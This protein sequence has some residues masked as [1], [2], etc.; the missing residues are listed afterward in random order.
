VLCTV[1]RVQDHKGHETVL[2]ALALLPEAERKEFVYVI[3]G[4]G[5]H[6][7]A[8]REL[9]N[10]LGVSQLVSWLGFVADSELPLVYQAADVFVLCTRHCAN[11]PVVEG[12]GLAFLEAQA[13]AIPVIGTRTGGIVDAIDEKAG[14]W[15]IEQDDSDRLA[16]LL[17]ELVLNPQVFIEAGKLARARVE[18]E[19]TWDHYS[20][21]LMAAFERYCISVS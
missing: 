13:C 7:K 10:T 18:K 2:R 17:H 5:P 16:Q 4:K 11:P 1:A 9:T 21:E 19:C 6:V 3:A 14:G 20:R 8:L 12:F 15:F